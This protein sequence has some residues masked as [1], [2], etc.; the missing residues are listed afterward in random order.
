[1]QRSKETRVGCSQSH[2]TKEAVYFDDD[3]GEAIFIQVTRSDKHI[4]KMRFFYEVLSKLKTAGT[5]IRTVDAYF[6]VKP[7]QYLNFKIDHIEDRGLL[8]EFNESWT[9]PEENRVKVRAFEPAPGAGR[10]A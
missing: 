5:V 3:E 6:V 8:T 1:M 7:T 2:E 9:C 4:F 10:R